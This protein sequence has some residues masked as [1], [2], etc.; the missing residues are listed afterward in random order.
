M[1]AASLL[2]ATFAL[3]ALCAAGLNLW[4][5][6]QRPRERA[7]LWLA[8]AA[9]GV[10]WLAA[11][12][13]A[14]Y[15]AETLA[16]AQRA[17]LVAL[18]AALPIVIGFA[19]FTNSFLR[20]QPGRLLRH[21]PVFTLLFVLAPTLYPPVFFSGEI[22]ERR[23]EPFGE[24]YVQ[25][26]LTSAAAIVL[27]MFLPLFAELVR[28][29][30]RNRDRI[31]GA[32]PLG[33][34]LAFW[35]VSASTDIAAFLGWMPTVH[36]MALGFCCFAFLFTGLLMRRFVAAA[37]RV[38]ASAEALQLEVEERTRLLRQKDLELAHGARMATVGALA[39]GLAHE[40]NDPIAFASSNLNHLAGSWRTTDVA[41]FDEVLGETRDGVERVR[42]VVSELLRLA[43][44][45]E[46]PEGPVDLREVVT[47][48]L[49]IVQPEA[50]WRARIVTQL[51]PVPPVRGE[52]RLLGQV[53]LNLVV[54]ALHS[55]PEG[56]PERY[57]VRIETRFRE[58]L[59]LLCVQDDGP[60]VAP[61]ALPHLFDPFAPPR[62]DLAGAEFGLA[63][64]HQLVSRHRGRIDVETS[65]HGT[66][67]TV[68]LPPAPLDAGAGL[69]APA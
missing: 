68:T 12:Q 64:T 18:T 56:Q 59:V 52:E 28:H 55:L 27:A 33:I 58:G 31:E 50:R 45:A 43:R 8:V 7:H 19:R 53:V 21:A 44:R 6:A 54:N 1:G 65:A 61:E 25:A 63:V 4:L 66:R 41:S 2:S 39:A 60:G 14:L 47:S 13:A 16:A 51:D 23:V 22:V 49:P 29:Y 26:G 37:S 30:L 17:Q 3:L 42:R 11:G 20:T 62:A 35:A 15:E 46:S 34:A 10:V 24:H 5:F 67:F 9:A 38:E 40:I 32:R 48:I 69:E 57:S 36:G